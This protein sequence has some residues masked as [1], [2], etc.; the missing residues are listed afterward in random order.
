M[1]GFTLIEILI[2]IG[3]L[4]ILIIIAFP[5]FRFFGAERDLDNSTEEI[6]STL[7][8]AQSQTLASEGAD[9]WGIYFSTSSVPHKYILFQG[10]NYASR[11][12][13]SDK[14]Y[15]L[16]ESVEIYDI[17]L[18]T[19]ESEVIFNRL[20][21]STGQPGNISLR[22][23]ADPVKTKTIYIE[24]SGWVGLIF[25]P[26]PSD[27]DRLKD[28][29]RVHFDLGWSI[30]NATTVKFSFPAIPQAEEVY[31]ADYFNTDKTV[32]DWQGKFVVDGADQVFRLHTHY[33][34]AFNTILC[35]HRDRNNN[36][37]DQEVIIYIK[38]EGIDKEIA[39]YLADPDDTVDKGFYVDTMERQ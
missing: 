28:S 9:Q 8:F 14:T 4:L 25:P 17:N 13:S 26:T 2:V 36:E 33:L 1:K 7:R 18:I 38:D 32:F 37:N 27:Q 24:N 21:G 30:Q 31:V 39:H 34:D 35:I 5:I 22:L 10:E 15:T 11:V 6:I 12:T 23:K 20:I 29:R 19:G 3:I 16:P